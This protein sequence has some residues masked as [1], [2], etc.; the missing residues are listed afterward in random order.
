M[1]KAA[2]LVA[3]DL[4][5]R[6]IRGELA[7]GDALPSETE[8]MAQFGVS[9]PTLREAI[10]VLES[11]SLIT[12]RRGARGGARVQPPRGA[13]AARYA[14]FTLE[15]RG[16]TLRDVHDAR[17]ALEIPSVRKLARDRTTD[18]LTLLTE[19]LDRE[20]ASGDAEESI[21]LHGDFHLLLVRLAGNQTL[22][23]FTEML[24]DIVQAANISLQPV[25]S[26]AVERARRS[27][28]KTHRRVVDY[29]QA[30]DERGTED[31]WRLHLAEAEGHLL[32]DDVVSTVSDLLR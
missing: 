30:R 4:R 27:T 8:L 10:R 13:A 32:G 29:I 18:D 21:K 11:E 16:V 20:A 22:T 6:I 2:E 5:R 1:P 31:L 23:L 3:V 12:I 25:P 17:A 24:H 15:Y 9:R 7:E 19:A 14:A 26:E 28:I